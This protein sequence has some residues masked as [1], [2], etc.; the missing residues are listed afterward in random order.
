MPEFWALW[1]GGPRSKTTNLLVPLLTFWFFILVSQLQLPIEATY[2]FLG[3]FAVVLLLVGSAIQR[4]SLLDIENYSYTDAIVPIALGA[5]AAGALMFTLMLATG[6]LTPSPGSIQDKLRLF[7]SQVLLVAVVEELFYRWAVPSILTWG[8]VLSPFLF[9]LS[10]PIV[11]DNL[12]AGVVTPVVLFAFVFFTAVGF[13]FQTFVFLARLD[14]GGREKLFGL[15]FTNGAHGMYN[16]I[17]IT[18][19][20]QVL[21]VPLVPFCGAC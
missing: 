16:A 12:A 13:L 8:P 2:A 3:L 17:V 19:S 4:R 9:G 14:L 6:N 15:P 21:G 10:H 5:V 18:F 1:R 7:G 20:L 11:R